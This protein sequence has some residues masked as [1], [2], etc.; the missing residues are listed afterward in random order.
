MNTTRESTGAPRLE[1]TSRSAVHPRAILWGQVYVDSASL[2]K[3][4]FM[5]TL[6][7]DLSEAVGVLATTWDVPSAGNN[8]HGRTADA[9]NTASPNEHSELDPLPVNNAGRYKP[10]TYTVLSHAMLQAPVNAPALQVLF[11][12]LPLL[13]FPNR[14]RTLQRPQGILGL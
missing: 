3:Y 4:T 2:V 9:Q 12:T 13:M 1:F 14:D 11:Q 7:G 6:P 10:L 8:D 5:S